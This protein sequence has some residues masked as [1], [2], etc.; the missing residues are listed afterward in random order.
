VNKLKQVLDCNARTNCIFLF[1]DF[2][3]DW[4]MVVGDKGGGIGVGVEDT[5]GFA[6]SGIKI[7]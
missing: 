2:T 1:N 4:Q 6:T 5:E 3:L 7:G